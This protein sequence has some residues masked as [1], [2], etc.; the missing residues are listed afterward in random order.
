[1]SKLFDTGVVALALIASVLYAFFS[2]G[3]KALRRRAWAALAR[4]AAGAHLEAVARRLAAAADEVSAGCGGCG[5]CESESSSGASGE[6]RVPLAKI[7]K[8][9]S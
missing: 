6:V 7:G 9:R 1:M 8:R 2:L 4:L 3:P 5:S